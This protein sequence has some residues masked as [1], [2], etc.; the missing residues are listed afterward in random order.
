MTRV[1]W[2]RSI[3]QALYE[4]GAGKAKLFELQ[5]QLASGKAFERAS[6]D[7]EAVANAQ[8]LRIRIRRDEQVV[9]NIEV[10]R[11]RLE[12]AETLMAA[13]VEQA[14]RVRT[15]AVQ[16]ANGTYTPGDLQAMA[17][18]VDQQLEA[19]LRTANS[20]SAGS[21]LFAGAETDRDAFTATRDSRGRIIAVSYNGD[22]VDLRIDAGGNVPVTWPGSRVFAAG[23]T[24]RAS[25]AAFWGGATAAE[26][27]AF[28]ANPVQYTSGVSGA[29]A[30]RELSAVYLP[31]GGSLEGAIELNGVRV[32]Y[33]LDADPTTGEGDSLLDLA[34]AINRSNAGVRAS[35]TGSMQGREAVDGAAFGV[36]TFFSPLTAQ[37]GGF[38]AGTITVNGATVSVTADDTVFTLANR[39]N[40]TESASGVTASVVDAAGNV[41]D[42]SPQAGTPPYRLRFTGGVELGDD[43]AGASNVL[44]LLGVTAWPALSSERNLVGE[45]T[46]PYRLTLTGERPG[47][48]TIRD[49]GGTLAADLGLSSDAGVVESGT[50]FATLI[51][52]RDALE[53]AD[54]ETLR[55]EILSE[56]DLVQ[57][58]TEVYR[59]E[60]G[61][62]MNR[63]DAQKARAEAVL[64]QTRATLAEIEEVDLAEII[65][66]LQ[67]QQNTQQA[68]LR[69]L[70]TVLNFSLLNFL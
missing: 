45:V 51:R 3:G 63:V 67:A 18:E 1:S 26:Y 58:S 23:S 10:N 70:S 41:V 31:S 56:L 53:A 14:R 52:M 36:A 40:A 62:R 47:P 57:Q 24:V 4:T 37:I 39:I 68:A 2:G 29:Y 28:Q 48:F 19:L 46:E 5:K 13:T 55:D 44:Q 64:V 43:H 65:T 30:N 17:A 54:Q 33:D 11:R 21:S 16:A 60:A 7:P 61:V 35:I 12:E 9:R 66:E 22:D 38:T 49:A 69:S 8:R 27:T 34:A 50:F 15:L 6:D 25:T 42:G 20:R 32:S 59:T